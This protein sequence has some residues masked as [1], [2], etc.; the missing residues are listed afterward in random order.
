[1]VYTGD[2]RGHTAYYVDT[3][4]LY[5]RIFGSIWIFISGGSYL[6]SSGTIF[7]PF[8]VKRQKKD[9]T[10]QKVIPFCEFIIKI[11]KKF[12]HKKPDRF[13]N[14]KTCCY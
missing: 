9:I 12:Y 4:F 2:A 3:V 5:W 7:V 8:H 11:G 1:M 13:K 14:R 10:I 6:V